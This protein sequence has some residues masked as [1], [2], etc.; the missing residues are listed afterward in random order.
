M[1]RRLQRVGG[2]NAAQPWSRTAS[3]GD[4]RVTS[5]R[6]NSH[7]PTVTGR[8]AGCHVTVASPGSR[9]GTPDAPHETGLTGSVARNGGLRN[10]GLCLPNGGAALAKSGRSPTHRQRQ[11]TSRQIEAFHADRSEAW[12]SVFWTEDIT[13]AVTTLRIPR[14]AHSSDLPVRDSRLLLTDSDA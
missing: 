14:P 10:G 12:S 9:D 6:R 3:V 1:K 2:C 11:I 7:V 13:R 5:H 4:G 8:G